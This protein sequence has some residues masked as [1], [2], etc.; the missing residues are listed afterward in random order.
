MNHDQVIY[1]IDA[2]VS[3]C[4]AGIYARSTFAAMAVWFGF[5]ALVA[6]KSV[7]Q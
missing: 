3:S 7:Q 6:L 4:S 1:V 2:L 5:M